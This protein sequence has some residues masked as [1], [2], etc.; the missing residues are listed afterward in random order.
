MD[1][2]FRTKAQAKRFVEILGIDPV[3]DGGE[4]AAMVLFKLKPKKKRKAAV[5]VG[6]HSTTSSTDHSTGDI[7]VGDCKTMVKEKR[8]KQ[9]LE[10]KELVE[11]DEESKYAHT[12]EAK[13]SNKKPKLTKSENIVSDKEVDDVKEGKNDVPSK[14][15]KKNAC[16]DVATSPSPKNPALLCKITTKVS[17]NIAESPQKNNTTKQSSEMNTD[18][19]PS[20]VE[21]VTSEKPSSTND[22]EAYGNVNDTGADRNVT[23]KIPFGT[24]SQR[25]KSKRDRQSSNANEKVP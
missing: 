8:K 24:E 16:I 20:V 15:R 2:K 23:N 14:E 1:Y 7:K 5:S 22:T 17:T 11:E 25:Q 21:N 18:E 12:E 3:I 19:S 10:S 6:K 4:E 13:T 9:V